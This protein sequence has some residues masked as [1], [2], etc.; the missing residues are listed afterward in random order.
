MAAGEY[1][2]VRSQ[3]E[4]FEYQIALERD[5][6]K[7]YPGGGGA[8]ARADLRRQG[9]AA[10]G[11]G[12]ARQADRGR[13]RARARHA[14]ARGAGAQ[15]GGARL[16][17]RR[18]RKLVPGVRRRGRAAA[19]A[20]RVR[21]GAERAAPSPS[22]VTGVA[23]FAIGATLSLFTGRSAWFSGGRMLVLGRARRRR[24]LRDRP[25]DRCR[26]RL[27]ARPRGRRARP[28]GRGA[29]CTAATRAPIALPA[30]G[31]AVAVLQPGREKSLQHRHP[32][33]F[34]GAIDRVEGDPVPATPWP[35]WP[36]TARWQALAA[37]S[38]ASQIRARV[39]TFDPAER[40]RRRLH[41]PAR[42]SRRRR[43]AGRCFDAA[44]TGARLVHG[45]SDGLPGVVADRYG[46]RGRAA[47]LVRRRR[48]LAQRHRRR[49]SRGLP[50]VTC[51]F[52]RSD[53]EVRTLEGLAPRVGLVAGE[54]ARPLVTVREDDLAYRVDAGGRAEDGLLPRPAR[55]PARS[56]ATS[57]TGAA[58]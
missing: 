44:H 32:W 53:A 9:P 25:P 47:M 37:W 13:P 7:Q 31:T 35:S 3:R 52:E 10:E 57:R 51:V 41:P 5:E 50:G 54:P 36:R 46:E 27:T 8:G 45:E 58:C 17:H 12:E 39:W 19:R 21:R 24:H 48:A 4:L 11:S 40:R 2:S 14:G 43:R 15:S 6:L 16:A 42:A 56:C 49:R 38:P 33:I 29:A 30:V 28:D 26:A 18:R 55:Q 34:S 20:V 22:G 23:L 1:V